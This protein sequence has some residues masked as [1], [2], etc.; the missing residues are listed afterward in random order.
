MLP[1]A[2][3][4]GIVILPINTTKGFCCAGKFKIPFLIMGKGIVPVLNDISFHTD[5]ASQLFV[6]YTGYKTSPDL[7]SNGK[8]KKKVSN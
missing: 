5:R 7:S 2:Q 8:K 6:G 1:V 3:Y 4:K